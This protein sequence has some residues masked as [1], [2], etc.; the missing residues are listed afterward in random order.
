MWGGVPSVKRQMDCG[1]PQGSILGSLLL[2]LYINDIICYSDI[3]RFILFADDTNL[4]YSNKDMRILESKVNIDH[5]KLSEWFRVNK[6]SLNV[7]KTNYIFFGNKRIP[8][9][10]Q[11]KIYLD[12]NTPERTSCTTFLVVFFP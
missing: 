9:S 11:P 7:V 2:I 5:S 1:V 8:N 10:I 3:L 6:L 4:F 12:G